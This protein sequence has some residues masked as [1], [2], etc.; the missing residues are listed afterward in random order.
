MK[1]FGATALS[2]LAVL[3][4]C[5]AAKDRSRQR[6]GPIRS[7]PVAAD[8]K[9]EVDF[10]CPEEF[11]Y[12]PHPSDC[13]LYYVC[14]FGGALLESCTGG[15]MYSHELQTCDWPRNVGCDATGAVV[16]EDLERI[17]ERDPPPPPRRNPPPPPRAQPN[18][19]ITSRGQPKFNRQEYEKQQQLYAEVDDLPPVEEIESDR[20]QRVYRGQPS[21]I[22]QV[23]KD[24]DGYV[25][26]SNSGRSFNTNI[27]PSSIN[28]NSKIGSFSFGTQ[29]DDRRTATITQAPQT[30]RDEKTDNVTD[31][32]DRPKDFLT[33]ISKVKD[34]TQNTLLRKK[35][36]VLVTSTN[37]SKLPDKLS[38]RSDSENENDNE[39]DQVMEYIEFDEPSSEDD[40]TEEDLED[41]ERGK[42]QIRFYLKN[43]FRQP[44]KIWPNSK[45][46]KLINLQ[47]YNF[48]PNLQN[49]R[50]VYNGEHNA[51][52]RK[53]ASNNNFFPAAN[54][55]VPY[56]IDNN[57]NRPFK[58]SIP[59]P[60]KQ[61]NP[62]FNGGTQIITKSPPISSLNNNQ[63][64][65]S[66]LAGGFYNNALLNIHN[67]NIQ[68]G[69]STKQPSLA[70]FS[71][72]SHQSSS[73]VTG[74]PLQMSSSIRT[75]NNYRENNVRQNEPLKDNKQGNKDED[76]EEEDL[77]SSE[78]EEDSSREE[79][80]DDHNQNF[81][82]QFGLPYS[83]NNPRHKFNKIENP[84]ANPEF[85]FD[86]FLDKLRDDH[87]SIVG[88]TTQN[89]TTKDDHN[90]SKI[91]NNNAVFTT[92]SYPDKNLHS[93]TI[94]N[95][96]NTPRP[97]TAS[98]EISSTGA[99][100]QRFVSSTPN[101]GQTYQQQLI[102]RPQTV[103]QKYVQ[104][105]Q[106]PVLIKNYNKLPQTTPT[107][108]AES[109]RP[110]IKPP[111]F[112]DDRQ[113]PLSYSFNTPNENI[114]QQSYA[115][116]QPT[117]SQTTP[118]VTQTPYLTGPGTAPP[119]GFLIPTNH[120]QVT[121]RPQLSSSTPNFVSTTQAQNEN[122]FLAFIRSSPKPTSLV[123]EQLSAFKNYWKTLTSGVTLPTT[124]LLNQGT[125]TETPKQENSYYRTVPSSTQLPV[126]SKTRVL[127]TS[128][129]ASPK[130]R[131][132]PK[133][134]PEMNDYYYDEEDEQYYYEPAV[135]PKYM[136]S[137]EV[138]PQRPLMAQNYK[139]YDDIGYTENTKI[140][141]SSP[142]PGTLNVLKQ[143][144]V[145]K[146]HN[147]LSVVTKTPYKQIKNIN[148]KIPVPV[149]VDYVS[150][151]NNQ[152]I[153]RNKTVHLRKP[154]HNP[155]T[156]RPPKYLNQTT[157][158]PYTVRHRLA[159]PTT[160]KYHIT[161]GENNKQTRER[162]RHQNIVAQNMKF[163]TPRDS[164]KQET[165]FTKTSHDD[166]TNSLEPTESITPTSYSAS[167]RPK[168]LYNGSQTYNADQYDPYYAVYDE[169]GELYKDTDYVQQYN[170]ASL[171][172]AVQQTY[173]GTPPPARR[174]VETYT[175]RPV[176]ADDYDDVLIQPQISN[177]N[178]YQSSIRQQTRSSSDEN[179]I[180]NPETTTN[181]NSIDKST[182]SLPS[183]LSPFINFSSLAKP[184][185]KTD[186]S[187]R[188]NLQ[189]TEKI[190]TR[191]KP[192]R[193]TNNNNA[194]KLV[195]Q[196][197][198]TSDKKLISLTTGFSIRRNVN[199]TKDP[200]T[201]TFISK[202]SESYFNSRN[203]NIRI[204]QQVKKQ[205]IQK[206][207]NL[208]DDNQ[209]ISE[210]YNDF[211]KDDNSKI[212]D[213]RA[214]SLV[215]PRINASPDAK[216]DKEPFVYRKP[217]V[218]STTLR[219]K[220]QTTTTPVMD[221]TK[222][223]L[224]TV[225]RRPAPPVNIEEHTKSN[226]NIPTTTEK[227]SQNVYKEEVLDENYSLSSDSNLYQ[228]DN[229]YF[230][231]KYNE[232]IILP[233]NAYEKQRSN[234]NKEV[235][236][237]DYP[238][239]L[240]ATSPLTV[241]KKLTLTTPKLNL[242]S[243]E[244]PSEKK[245]SYYVYQVEDDVLADQTTEV[246]NVRNIIKNILNN[247]SSS[248]SRIEK[249][250]STTSRTTPITTTTTTEENIVRIGVQKKKTTYSDEKPLKSMLKHLKIITEPTFVHYI[251]PTV[252]TITFTGSNTQFNK[253]EFSP[254]TTEMPH[255]TDATFL[256]SMTQAGRHNI[257]P[258][259]TYTPRKEIHKSKFN[260][261]AKSKIENEKSRK[262]QKIIDVDGP[263]YDS[264]RNKEY[265]EDGDLTHLTE[266]NS[267]T[268]KTPTVT[269][270]DRLYNDIVH[271]IAST[272]ST[273]K[274]TTTLKT[275]IETKPTTKSISFPTRASRINPAIKLAVENIGGGRRSYQS[276]SNC[277]S[278]NSL[279]ANSK[280]NEIKYQRP[281][282]TRGRGSAHFS[283]SGGSESSPQTP[284]RGTPPT[285]SRPT[286][287]PSTAIV[288]KSADIPDIYLNPPSRPEA[289]YP[290][291]TPDKTAAKCRKDVCLLPDCFCGGKDIPG[292]LPVDKV[293]QIVLL[294]YDDS[295]NDL[296]KGLYADLFE[297]GRVNPN[298][299]PI[300]A[301]FYVSH[302]W[303]DYSQ[304]QNLYSA[305]HEMA[306]HTVSH[307][308]GEQF[309]Q[310]KWNREIGGQ[311]EILAAYGG[312][313]L[314]DI[315]GMRAPFLSVG[316]N[317]MF[318]M[319]YD[320]NFTYDSSLPVYENKPPSWPYTLDYKLFHD[321][322]IPP[323][324][325]K[326]YPGVW[327]VPMVMWQDLNG[328]RCSMGDACAN[329]P[330]SDGVYKMILKNFDRHYTSNRAPFGLFYHAAWF[331]QPH[332]KEGFI[333]FL[334]FI[335]KMPDV[336]IV[337]NWQAIQWVRDPTPISRLNNFQPFQCNY[338]DRPKKCNNAKVCNLWHKSGVRYMRTC[339]PCPEIYPWTGKTGIRSSRIDN[340]IED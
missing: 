268:I 257:V 180:R 141:H 277:S 117:Y 208:T 169:D 252:E 148:G 283:T 298:G 337:T 333:K 123:D 153:S 275:E 133:P 276:S 205:H 321:C 227:S 100:L 23:Q 77:G 217:V 285:R 290:Q 191:R 171:R 8:I 78:E 94:K 173:R 118:M 164:Y 38:K 228:S 246:F 79:E 86:T 287:K 47:Q 69:H 245:P 158:R 142:K 181:Q 51:N 306:S 256:D 96:Q 113:L 56:Q 145:T 235:T 28:Q 315:R 29:V 182:S 150:P 230:N 137:S 58:P 202:P 263:S 37:S 26:Q 10:D 261:F 41:S 101:Q 44:D 314:D 14:V 72:S 114:H 323:C 157:L 116:R 84:F 305:G 311:R 55:Y 293:P 280:C 307:S 80:N 294:T 149:L 199:N 1:S 209:D 45:P 176:L 303:T 174:P 90:P 212:N 7:V 57:Q 111:N 193:V 270:N 120:K 2:V 155:N 190:P 247:F 64:P 53:P 236:S 71:D 49:Q 223:Y 159:K 260:N 329:P 325:T 300:T 144:S 40:Y 206:L 291:P 177:Q 143:D 335:N 332:H 207:V 27:I 63:N 264:S 224:K 327:E 115:L 9:R 310:K 85:N 168:M 160:E 172:P 216:A 225:L 198:A 52:I 239:G 288:S 95:G 292:D 243:S 211:I 313:K 30:Y 6:S 248:T 18:P 210:A 319:L 222:Y 322:M 74:K 129:T 297:K 50:L 122:P 12:Y 271:D 167:P 204:N 138:K 82:V 312:V 318:K 125:V 259:S 83:Y 92:A 254:T 42:R 107:I 289:V 265:E 89:P 34:I 106:E 130:R 183:T 119:T 136:P 244:N 338:A 109:L 237:E 232:P 124:L 46:I 98:A 152:Y 39:N 175:P 179:P 178:Q 320:S 203:R 146:N 339:Q 186:N 151:S 32:I 308:F 33:V 48:N 188:L 242:V 336:W 87:Y 215:I 221:S 170:Q 61:K 272:T 135:K 262:Y 192:S 97:F 197:P 317:K 81:P 269:E 251:S 240:D 184:F 282:S 154:S 330:D 324:P 234:F 281:S 35:R 194:V 302:E 104:N 16:A 284:N 43:G 67:T 226:V 238:F 59:D 258:S 165:R 62:Q 140:S 24:R 22:G 334:D 19:V 231:D 274:S 66:A 131:P 93:S 253:N 147:D 220:T 75:P 31:S 340:D 266:N 21:T 331:T 316:G 156:L 286:L 187:Y 213:K 76:Y 99:T 255:V 229:T 20:Q 195:H 91:A 134:S 219:Q 304:V 139:E 163:T 250:T 185:E 127:T 201:L 60:I 88:V 200:Y 196:S 70:S 3:T 278:D 218:E 132:I 166:R 112:K 189:S 54:S 17:N 267:E 121:S 214:S 105:T 241:A 309:S 273:T 11:G 126:K 102:Q 5:L 279:Q 68:A 15:L 13:T 162:V 299:C 328:G 128:T 103:P 73:I 161:H 65:F 4:V 25:S 233:Y 249:S 36:D 110:N 108:Q 296:N 295:V 301:T 326:S